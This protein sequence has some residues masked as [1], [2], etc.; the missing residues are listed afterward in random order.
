MLK[1]E[2]LISVSLLVLYIVFCSYITN[3]QLEIVNIST[4]DIA[5]KSYKPKELPIARIEIER[6]NINNYIYQ[7]NSEYNHVDKNVTLLHH[8]V[9]PDKD[10]SIVFLAAHSGNSKVSYF[11]HLNKIKLKENIN[12]YY[13][14]YKYVYQT[15][16][17][18]ET[19][20]DG[21]IELNKR[22]EKQLVLTTCSTTDKTKQLVIESVLI[23]KE[24][25]SSF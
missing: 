2:Y 1:K 7:L 19:E 10:N 18:T 11:N 20:K 21:D 25:I 5:L 17:I 24:K 13:D 22:A 12:F 15:I 16:N 3:N 23:R 14:D 4:S 8:S 6:L 9:F